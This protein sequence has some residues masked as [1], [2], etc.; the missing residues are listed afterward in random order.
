MKTDMMSMLPC[1]S[2]TRS[3]QLAETRERRHLTATGGLP[4]VWQ[5]WEDFSRLFDKSHQVGKRK[6]KAKL[7]FQQSERGTQNVTF[8]CHRCA[9]SFSLWGQSSPLDLILTPT[10][11]PK[12]CH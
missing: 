12:H 8:L 1:F 10:S 7:K 5:D 4:E 11:H 3:G 2:N 9:F 6:E